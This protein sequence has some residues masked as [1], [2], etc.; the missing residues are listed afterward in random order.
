ML[1][2]PVISRFVAT[3]LAQRPALLGCKMG[4]SCRF[5]PMSLFFQAGFWMPERGIYLL[6]Y[7]VEVFYLALNR[8]PG[9]LMGF[10]GAKNSSEILKLGYL[11]G[12]NLKPVFK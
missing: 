5:F 10:T 8:Q 1:A 9:F 4:Q 2:E 11:S 12:A 6:L 7:P 3:F